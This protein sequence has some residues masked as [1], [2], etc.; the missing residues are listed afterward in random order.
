MTKKCTTDIQ[1]IY[2]IVLLV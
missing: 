1:H 2:S